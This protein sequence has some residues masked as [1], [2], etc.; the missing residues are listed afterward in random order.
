[1]FSSYTLFDQLSEG[2]FADEGLVFSIVEKGD[3]KFLETSEMS[4]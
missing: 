1:M 3:I 4:S 2:L